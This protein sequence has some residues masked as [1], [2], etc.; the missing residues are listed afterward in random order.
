M[1]LAHTVGE[2]NGLAVQ[3]D[4]RQPTLRPAAMTDAPVAAELIYQPMGRMADYLFGGDDR[5]C[6][7]EVFAKLFA[8]SQNRFSHQFSD[9]L[10]LGREV[11]G[12]LLSYPAGILGG[13]SAPMAKQLREIIGWGAMARLVH[14]SAPLMMLKEYEP[15]EFYIFTVSVH[16]KFQHRGFGKQLLKHAEDKAK[17]AGLRK[18]SLGVTVD[19]VGA[20]R[21]YERFNYRIVETVRVPHLESVIQYPGYH[22]MVKTLPPDPSRGGLAEAAEAD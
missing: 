20:I 15:D 16:P 5:D 19:N 22:R 4:L 9:M 6:A 14:R 10:E 12:M 11:A 21:L 2:A 18:C 8:Q 1:A 17:A 7:L 3:R 13:L